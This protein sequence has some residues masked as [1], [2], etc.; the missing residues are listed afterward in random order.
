ML[1]VIQ[2]GEESRNLL[3]GPVLTAIAALQTNAAVILARGDATA[4]AFAAAAGTAVPSVTI[5]TDSHSFTGPAAAA[6]ETALRR[7]LA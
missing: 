7:N 4:M 6:L 5:D 3:S 2:T 1:R